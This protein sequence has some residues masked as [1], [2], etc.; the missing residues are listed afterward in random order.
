LN[1]NPKALREVVLNLAVAK[2][3]GLQRK[4]D[5]GRTAL[6]DSD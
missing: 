1:E 2:I 6:I 5:W 3:D 4:H